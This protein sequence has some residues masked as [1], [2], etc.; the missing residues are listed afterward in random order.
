[1]G[2]LIHRASVPFLAYDTTG[3]SRLQAVWFFLLQNAEI[4]SKMTKNG[5]VCAEIPLQEDRIWQPMK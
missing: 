3:G 2:Q 1:M 5:V 4:W